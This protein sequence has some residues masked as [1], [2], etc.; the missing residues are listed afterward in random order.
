MALLERIRGAWDAL[1]YGERRYGWNTVLQQIEDYGAAT[2][3]GIPVTADNALRC[4]AVWACVRVAVETVATLPLHV[5]RTQGKSKDIARDHPV[6]NLLHRAPNP[7]QTKVEFLEQMLLA[8]ELRGN[9]FAEIVRNSRGRIL[10]LW[11]R[12]PDRMAV[13]RGADGKVTYTYTA[14]NGKRTTI[15]PV[16]MLHFRFM[17]SDGL[18]GKSPITYAAETVALG[19]AARRYGAKVFSQ[20]GAQRVALSTD[21]VLRDEEQVKE[22]KRC[23]KA[24]YGSI[25]NMGEVAVLH[26]GLKPTIIGINPEDAQLLELLNA[27]VYDICRIWRVPPH[28]VANLERATFSNIEHQAIEW[29]VDGVVPRVVR[30]EQAMDRALLGGDPEY[31]TKFNINGL[32]RGDFKTRMEG[33]QI[34][35]QNAIMSPNEARELDEMNPYPE[36]DIHLQQVNMAPVGWTPDQAEPAKPKADDRAACGCGIE[37][38]VAG[39]TDRTNPADFRHT[40]A[41]GNSRR[42]VRAQ[43]QPVIEAAYTRIRKREKAEILE[44][45]E[46]FL[47]RRSTGDFWEWLRSWGVA[48][49]E[50]VLNV[51][52]PAIEGMERAMADAAAGELGLDTP[53][54]IGDWIKGFLQGFSRNHTDATIAAVEQMMAA[55]ATLDEMLAEIRRRME[56]WAE[57]AASDASDRI[58]Q[59]DGAV[60]REVWKRL[61][62]TKFRW[63]T[64]G[65]NCPFCNQIAGK[66]V[67]VEEHFVGAGTTL[68][69]EGKTPLVQN[70]NILFPPLHKGCDCQIAAEVS[71]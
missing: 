3:T 10:A 67:G 44:A 53:A 34:A 29:V 6:Y 48:H 31:Y 69:A 15:P 68:E 39:I 27:T 56:T 28:K 8:Y 63:A 17:S 5:Y 20:G 18:M 65:D 36:G 38:V 54:E 26:S 16:N 61:G 11:P 62:V 35:I 25:E 43:W 1:R 33:Y 58:T 40:R 30:L 47:G 57:S 42:K 52:G 50:W 24:N 32:L 64:V 70:R 41:D 4:A 46:K 59:S 66:V 51:I 19:L 37:H 22:F 49:P 13:A 23:W 9:A 60:T 21:A 2:D 7:E 45:A 12:H 55:G 14:P 71:L